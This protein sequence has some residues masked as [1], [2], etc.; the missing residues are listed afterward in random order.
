M[1]GELIVA[2]DH[3]LNEKMMRDFEEQRALAAETGAGG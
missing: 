1:S 2:V 3:L